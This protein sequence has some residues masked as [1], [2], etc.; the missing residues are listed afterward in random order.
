MA[1]VP[2]SLIAPHFLRD[3]ENSVV[4]PNER[5]LLRLLWRNPGLSRS[6]ITGHT[7][8]TQ[9]SIHRILDQ[10][11][12]RGIVSLGSPKPGLGRGQP[13]P[14]LRLD[15]R[16]AYSCG[17]SVNTD[18]ID[19]CLMDLAGNRLGERS[20]MLRE[21]S[22]AQSLDL[23]RE[24]VDE[25][26]RENGLSHQAFFGIGLAIAGFHVSGT[27]Y[28]ASLPLHEW[29][30]I[31]LGPLLTDLFGKPAWVLNGGKAGAVAESMF[32]AGRYIRHF[33]Y[34]SFNYGFGGGIIS[35]GELL[36]GGSGNAGEFSQMY[37]EEEVTRRP[38]LQLL[39]ERLN[40]NGV[41]VPSI[42]YLRRHFDPEWP[43]VSDWVDEITPAYNRLVNAIWAVFDPQ[44]IIFGGQ[45][46]AALAQLVIERTELFGRPR[47][48]FSRPSPKLIISDISTDASAM[49]AAIIPFK[50]TYYSRASPAQG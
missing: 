3:G 30:L 5:G 19:I 23:L 32:G 33:A 17:I 15:G 34:L 50:S 39:I 20:L 21:R 9:Q 48:G 41:V 11:A 45:V 25:L 40:R 18:V 44:A 14:M 22:M 4:S 6:E 46:P 16:H 47:Y 49:G 13:S 27:R 36:H 29:S 24:Q 12:E 38:A 8:L 28:N 43:G 26:Q 37:D 7:D 35:D 2:E 31:E 42:T 1:Y 10:L